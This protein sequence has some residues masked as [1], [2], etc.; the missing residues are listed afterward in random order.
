M[1]EIRKLK[2]L[3]SSYTFSIVSV[4]I[5]FPIPAKVPYKIVDISPITEVIS[6]K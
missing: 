3:K 1:A 2:Y 5:L 6:K 4:M